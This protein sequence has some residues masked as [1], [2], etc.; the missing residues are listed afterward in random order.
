MMPPPLAI[1]VIVYFPS[2]TPL[3]TVTFMVDVPDPGLG[4]NEGFKPTVVPIG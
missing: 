3:P 2:L 1:I 4:M